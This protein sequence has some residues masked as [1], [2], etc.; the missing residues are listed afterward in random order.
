MAN[1]GLRYAEMEW[2]LRHRRGHL[3]F[4]QEFSIIIRKQLN[5]LN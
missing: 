1:F 2:M 4:L 5:E 3:L